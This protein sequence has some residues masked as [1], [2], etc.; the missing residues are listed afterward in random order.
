MKKDKPTNIT[1]S[2]HAR[3]LNKA[4]E[5]NR[6]FNEILQY[7]AMERFLYR[8]SISDYSDKFILKGALMLR[9]YGI[10]DA[11]PTMDI[12]LKGMIPNRKETLI[13]FVKDC[14]NIV[15]DDGI[16]YLKTSV[17]AK[18]ITPD[19]DYAGIRLNFKGKLGNAVL[20]YQLDIGFGDRVT[21]EPKF[22][23]YPELLDFGR[24]NILVYS[25]ETSIAEKLQAMIE[26]DM[27]N[28][29][30]K[31]FYDIDDISRHHSFEGPV[32]QQAI[33]DTFAQRNT[34]INENVPLAL[35]SD[36]ADSPA[37]NAQWNAFTKRIRMTNPDTL[38]AV[39]TRISTF[40]LPVLISIARKQDFNMS[41]NANGQWSLQ[42]EV[43]P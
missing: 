13:D 14:M 41:W 2:I 36:F 26:L 7:Y 4:Q 6:P 18:D 21:P 5:Q 29:R 39:I 34:P 35:T 12:D 25:L 22:M 42:A 20:H 23:E 30:M 17:T 28:S 8:L 3:L 33:I 1:A 24:P 19:A 38:S 11:R 37:K 40:I 16:T 32:L 15:C 10:P 27:A 31:D 43:K 9:V